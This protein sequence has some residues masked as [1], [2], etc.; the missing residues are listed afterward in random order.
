MSDKTIHE[1]FVAAYQQIENP[2]KDGNANYGA[3]ATLTEVLAKVKPVL[4]AHGLALVQENVS[5]EHGVGVHTVIYSASGQSLDFGA[6][7][8]PLQKRDPQGAGSAITY[9]RRYALKSIFGL[10]EVDDDGDSASREPDYA[11]E[12]ATLAQV[13]TDNDTKK[14]LA[15]AMGNPKSQKAALA[16]YKAMSD[17]ERK[18]L[19]GIAAGTIESMKG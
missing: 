3:F 17:A 5:D 19:A 15:E 7:T 14:A 9:A 2:T 18:T 10:S 11:G 1:A 6:L 4:A 12:L 8:L 13:A 16:V